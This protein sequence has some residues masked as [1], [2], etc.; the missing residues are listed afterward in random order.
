MY[1]WEDGM[2][3]TSILNGTKIGPFEDRAGPYVMSDG[4]QYGIGYGIFNKDGAPGE[5]LVNVNGNTFPGYGFQYTKRDSLEWFS[6]LAGGRTSDAVYNRFDTA[7]TAKTLY[8]VEQ[9]PEGIVVSVKGSVLGPYEE[10][11]ELPVASG[12][13]MHWGFLARLKGD[14]YAV[15]I[16]GKESPASKPY[17]RASGF[18]MSENGTSWSFV[19]SPD[20]N[21]D[22][23]RGRAC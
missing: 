3:G 14:C 21:S 12:D 16:D 17:G 8:S 23:P 2:L 22:K 5:R 15:V 10:I 9:K 13:G 19:A 7:L 4:I 11:L 20:K 1:G 6:W 18:S